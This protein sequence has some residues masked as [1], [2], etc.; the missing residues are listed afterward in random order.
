MTQLTIEIPEGLAERLLPL[1]ARL[2]EILAHGLDELS[3]LPNQ[4]YRYILQFLVSHPTSEALLNF[5]P[6]PAMLARAGELLDKQRATNLDAA[7][8]AELDEYVRIN[9]LVTMLKARALPY[10]VASN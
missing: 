5:G 6:T 9:H 4:V 7:E 3:P 2:P 10:V 8:E 1:Q